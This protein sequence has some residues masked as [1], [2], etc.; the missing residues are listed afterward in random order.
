MNLYLCS[1]ESKSG[2]SENKGY[3]LLMASEVSLEQAL[4]E[5][6]DLQEYPDIFP[7]NL[8]EFPSEKEVKFEGKSSTRRG[9]NHASNKI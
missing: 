5:I 7:E 3:I 8:P 1:L 2:R 4:S 9:L 6:S